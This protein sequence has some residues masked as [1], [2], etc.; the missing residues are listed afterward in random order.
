MAETC[1]KCKIG[2]LTFFDGAFE[3]NPR[4]VCSNCNATFE[5]DIFIGYLDEEGILH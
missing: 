1:P 5:E 4:F 3:H 2:R